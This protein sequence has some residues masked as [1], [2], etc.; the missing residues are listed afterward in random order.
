MSF[1]NV[2]MLIGLA[3]VLIPVLIHLFHRRKARDIDWGAMQFLLGSVV[4]RN[5]RMLLEEMLLLALRCLLLALL[6][7]ALAL[8]FIPP[9]SRVP[10]QIVL[11]AVLLGAALLGTGTALWAYRTWRWILYG[12]GAA[13]LLIAAS[14]TISEWWFQSGLWGHAAG[15]QDVV[16]IIDGSASMAVEVDGRTNFERAIEEAKSLVSKLG[17]DDAASVIIA[18]PSPIVKHPSPVVQPSRLEEKMDELRPT[19]GPMAVRSALSA[20]A[21]TLA[22]GQNPTKT[23]VFITDAQSAGWRTRGRPDWELVAETFKNV[24]TPQ[25]VIRKLSMPSDFRNVQIADISMSRAVIGPDRPATIRAQVENTGN[26]AITSPFEVEFRIDGETRVLRLAVNKLDPGAAETVTLTHTFDTGGLHTVEARLTVKDDLMSDNTAATVFRTVERLPVLIIEGNPSRQP[27]DRAAAFLT[28]ALLPDPPADPFLEDEEKK[29]V[30]ETP[31]KA[32]TVPELIDLTIVEALDV[33]ALRN[34]DR[35]Q[36][37]IFADVPKLPPDAAVRF[38]E[39]VADGGALL[40]APGNRSVPEFYNAWKTPRGVSIAPGRMV[41]RRVLAKDKDP[42]HPAPS[43][44]QHPALQLIAANTESDI[45]TAAIRAYWRIEPDANDGNVGVGG[46]LSTGDPFLIGR[47]VGKG[48]VL[49]TAVSLDRHAGNL[50]TLQCF[51]PLVHEVVYSLRAAPIVKLDLDPANRLTVPLE[52]LSGRRPGVDPSL[53]G[54]GL[55]AAYFGS[56]DFRRARFVRRDPSVQFSWPAAPA[57]G[58]PAD[59]FSVRW[60]GTLLAPKTGPYTFKLQGDEEARLWIDNKLLIESK[61]NAAKEAKIELT[62]GGRH[63]IRIQH[64]ERTGQATCNAWWSGPGFGQQALSGSQF[65]PEEPWTADAGAG[66][67]AALQPPAGANKRPVGL[68]A[69]PRGVRVTVERATQAGLYRLGLPDTMTDTFHHLLVDGTVPFAVR[70]QPE[71]SQLDAGTD[72]LTDADFEGTEEHL[73]VFPAGSTSDMLHAI[74]GG[75]PGQRLW[76]PMALA[77]FIAAILEIALAQ[78]IAR[79]RKTGA[80]RKV[81]FT[82]ATDMVTL[83]DRAMETLRAGEAAENSR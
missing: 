74:T 61:K 58:I 67:T 55:R 80:T 20:A 37:I 14:I 49:M 13:L 34:L 9:G 50:P 79:Q 72:A 81:D 52:T 64:I 24:S 33:S 45:A 78:W 28:A 6:A 41:E 71:E 44:F 68:E 12:V 1:D 73:E 15:Q 17:P 11:P 42:A 30:P 53:A 29:D 76:K 4:S 66:L 23:V 77:A 47:R 57:P 25:L 83:R 46:A 75:I 70:P 3:A 40:I 65:S 26:V 69:S 39:Y 2:P 48:N 60:T 22:Q 43:T 35:F 27:L 82:S 21:I 19:G 7:L 51:V 5:R 32:P 16:I 62:A 54:P 8:P 38:A 59:H 36:V 56:P 63:A 10:W 31:V 18:G